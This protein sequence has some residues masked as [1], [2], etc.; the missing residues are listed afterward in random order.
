MPD[1]YDNARGVSELMARQTV[2]Q[3]IRSGWRPAAQGE[4]PMRS[5]SSSSSRP[6]PTLFA[7]VGRKVV[8]R[9]AE[10]GKDQASYVDVWGEGYTIQGRHLGECPEWLG[11]A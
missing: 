7:H 9:K 6:P 4:L 3:E 2:L 11:Q 10:R 1:N 5:S 8:H